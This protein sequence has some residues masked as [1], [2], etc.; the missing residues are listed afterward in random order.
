MIHLLGLQAVRLNN[1]TMCVSFFPPGIVYITNTSSN[2][3][4]VVC[5]WLLLLDLLI[6]LLMLLLPCCCQDW[7]SITQSCRHPSNTPL[8]RSPLLQRILLGIIWLSIWWQRVSRLKRDDYI[9]TNDGTNLWLTITG[10]NIL[11]ASAT[12]KEVSTKPNGKS[13]LGYWVSATNAIKST[14]SILLSLHYIVVLCWHLKSPSFF[15]FT[16]LIY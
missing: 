12:Y 9:S 6:V 16:F 8:L 1:F 10:K 2:V 7:S 4:L 13:S 11:F 15:F 14:V 5:C 3:L